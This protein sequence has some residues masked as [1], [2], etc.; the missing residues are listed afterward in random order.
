M[1][2]GQITRDH[3]LYGTI[4]SY[5]QAIYQEDKDYNEVEFHAFSY[6]LTET[7]RN[8]YVSTLRLPMPEL[9]Y[10][11]LSNALVD[12]YKSGKDDRARLI[13]S[14]IGSFMNFVFV[15]EA[16]MNK[17]RE[18]EVPE[19]TLQFLIGLFQWMT[20]EQGI[21]EIK[22]FMPTA[23]SPPVVLFRAATRMSQSDPYITMTNTDYSSTLVRSFPTTED[24]VARLNRLRQEG[25]K[26]LNYNMYAIRSFGSESD[27]FDFSFLTKATGL[28]AQNALVSRDMKLELLDLTGLQQIA[29]DQFVSIPR[30]VR[31]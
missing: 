25:G 30:Y 21:H 4:L 16:T 29:T 5:Y 14:I 23:N 1:L 7:L 26:M 13:K 17:W 22:R 20:F 31:W 15:L 2:S 9:S 8:H 12:T 10:N 11:S 19:S 6:Q 3:P 24:P 28:G 18:K 27:L